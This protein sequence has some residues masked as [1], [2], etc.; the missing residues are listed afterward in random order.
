MA[1]QIKNLSSIHEDV[2]LIPGLAQCV[3]DLVLHELCGLGHTHGLDPELL[4]LW[5][6]L[7][8]AA[9]VRPLPWECPYAAHMALKRQKK[10]KKKKNKKTKTPPKKK[11]ILIPDSLSGKFS[12]IWQS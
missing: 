6:R 4:W 5:H 12:N 2:G 3:R 1:Q 10:K 7:A 9:S 11:K 8:T